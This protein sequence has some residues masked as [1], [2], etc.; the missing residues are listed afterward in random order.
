MKPAIQKVVVNP[1]EVVTAAPFSSARAPGSAVVALWIAVMSR[2][3]STGLVRC[4]AKP[5]SRLA[6]TSSSDPYP[7]HAT[8]QPLSQMPDDREPV[9]SG[10][11]M[12]R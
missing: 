10:S 9:L 12:L 3:R 7:L 1:C 6:R 2:V 11:S 5:A 4:S 8:L